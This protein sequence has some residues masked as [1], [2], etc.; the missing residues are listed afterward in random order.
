[1]TGAGTRK[2]NPDNTLGKKKGDE[3]NSDTLIGCELYHSLRY[4]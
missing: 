4:T 2:V 3:R 1:M